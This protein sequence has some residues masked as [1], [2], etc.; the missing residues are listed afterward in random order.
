[1]LTTAVDIQEQH[2]ESDEY[3]QMMMASPARPGDGNIYWEP[4][5]S[6]NEL[7]S[8]LCSNKYREIAREQVK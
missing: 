2:L 8:Q 3:C 1:M 7:Y 5:G 4:A 6:I